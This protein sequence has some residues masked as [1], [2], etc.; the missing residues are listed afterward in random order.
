MESMD[1]MENKDNFPTSDA[2]KMANRE[3]KYAGIPASEFLS[4]E[5]PT[6]EALASAETN[7]M[8]AFLQEAKDKGIKESEGLARWDILRAHSAE[9]TDPQK[10]AA[11]RDQWVNAVG[12]PNELSAKQINGWYQIRD[13]A[14]DQIFKTL[15]SEDEEKYKAACD[16]WI[17]VGVLTE[18]DVHDVVNDNAK[19]NLSRDKL[20]Q[21]FSR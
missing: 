4:G 11:L 15:R 17:K 1:K 8:N 3:A 9:I 18:A 16:G 12:D 21:I 2:N 14:F 10:F 13:K 7:R 6:R 20:S 19:A 5:K